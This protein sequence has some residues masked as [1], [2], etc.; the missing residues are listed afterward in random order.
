MTRTILSYLSILLL[1]GVTASAD[2]FVV[3]DFNDLQIGEQ[4]LGYYNG[5]DGSLGTGPGPDR[6]RTWALPSQV[7]SLLWRR[8]YLSLRSKGRN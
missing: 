4:V 6:A 2:P 8:G 7:I 1:G 5:G 3:L